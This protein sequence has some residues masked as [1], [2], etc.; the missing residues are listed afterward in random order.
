MGLPENTQTG[1]RGLGLPTFCLW[2]STGHPGCHR[3]PKCPRPPA[4]RSSHQ[5]NPIMRV[6]I[7][8]TYNSAIYIQSLASLCAHKILTLEGR[9]LQ[10]CL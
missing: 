8:V 4:S 2:G 3:Q 5:L 1:D 10:K 6:Y 7:T 9:L